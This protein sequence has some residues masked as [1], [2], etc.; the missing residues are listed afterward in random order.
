MFFFFLGFKPMIEARAC[1]KSFFVL[2]LYNM[3]IN[4][5]FHFHYIE[6][7]LFS[8]PAEK[9]Y[10]YNKRTEVNYDIVSDNSTYNFQYE[11]SSS[12]LNSFLSL[13]NIRANTNID[14]MQ[15][16]YFSKRNQYICYKSLPVL[17]RRIFSVGYC[18][19]TWDTLP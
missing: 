16:L 8:K 2:I 14:I 17:C 15:I 13:I 9:T 10:N 12:F 18:A 3:F 1:S 4:I 11:K 6:P 19:F 5:W 7:E